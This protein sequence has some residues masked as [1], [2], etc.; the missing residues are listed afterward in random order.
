MC[1]R[2]SSR[3][4]ASSGAVWPVSKPKVG[5]H[6]ATRRWADAF[7]LDQ[8]EILY[9]VTLFGEFCGTRVDAGAG[10]LVDLQTLDD[11]D[12]GVLR[13]DGEGRDESFGDS[14]GT[15]G[16][17]GHR[18]PVAFRR[19]LEPVAGVIDRR[20]SSRGRR[21]GAA[22][23][24]DRRAALLHSRDEVALEPSLVDEFR[25]GLA[26]DGGLESVSYTHLRAHETVLDL[27]CRLLLEK[28]K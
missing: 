19:T 15:I 13:G 22:C 8:A 16:G 7:D 10:E 11:G 18:E 1:I 17:D 14:I 21:R 9:R 5:P 28:K 2:D 4:D 3:P 12:L 24:D 23:F 27:V 20:G 6:C 25:N 26:A